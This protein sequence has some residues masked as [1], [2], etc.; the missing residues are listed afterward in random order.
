MYNGGFSII[1]FKA[2]ATSFKFNLNYPA[3]GTYTLT[4]EALN[5]KLI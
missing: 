2:E 1:A 5:R 3:I 4:P